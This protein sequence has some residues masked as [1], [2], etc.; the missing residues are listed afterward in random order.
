MKS[1]IWRCQ[2]RL[3]ARPTHPVPKPKLVLCLCP[4]KA[5]EG[6]PASSAAWYFS[7]GFLHCM[8]Y[9]T[10]AAVH[11][12]GQAGPANVMYKACVATCRR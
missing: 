8:L 2:V 3:L 9:L 12:V 4:A 6:R 11:A 10:A 1:Q 7:A 5:G